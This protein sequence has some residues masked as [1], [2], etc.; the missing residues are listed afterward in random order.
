[1]AN[2]QT[3]PEEDMP[4]WKRELRRIVDCGWPE[5]DGRI[6]YR[7]TFRA[8]AETYKKWREIAYG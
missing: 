5:G 8:H 4:E 7:F 2:P 3:T 1:M 6:F